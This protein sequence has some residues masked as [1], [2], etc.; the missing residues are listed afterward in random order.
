MAVGTDT[1]TGTIGGGALEWQALAQARAM[2]ASGETGA[3]R[4]ISLG[5][6]LGQCC[7]GAVTLRFSRTPRPLPAP[8][9]LPPLPEVRPPETAPLWLWGAGHVGRAMVAAAPPDAF[10]ITWADTAPDRF[11]E[12]VPAHVTRL[13]AA[14]LPALA[15]HAPPD[16]HHLIFTYSHDIDLAL[17]QALL[18]RPTASIGLIGSTTKW[19][20]FRSRLA[21]VGHTPGTL[22]RITCPIGDPGAG[23]HPEAIANSTLAA[24]LSAL[25][26]PE[27][28]AI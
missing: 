7:G 19:A 5:P 23:K 4:T 9:P 2:L 1:A 15:A 21:A 17:C 25:A 14:D 12:A 10:D 24:L 20:R 27:T 26:L 16:A 13:P 18:S 6:G 8:P 22:L 28:A 11:P 3:E